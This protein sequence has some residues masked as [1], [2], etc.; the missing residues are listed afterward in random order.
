MMK[1]KVALTLAIATLL[2]TLSQARIAIKKYKGD[3]VIIRQSNGKY[4]LIGT[5]HKPIITNVETISKR[6][7]GYFIVK[8]DEKKGTC[9]N[10]KQLLPLEFSNISLVDYG[11]CLVT[12]D[13]KLGLYTD[14]G[15]QIL[16]PIYQRIKPTDKYSEDEKR[17]FIVKNNKYGICNSDGDFIIEPQYDDITYNSNDYFVMMK[18]NAPE[19]L[20]NTEN[21]IKGVT[22]DNREPIEIQEG[23]ATILY[24]NYKRGDLWGLLN[25]NGRSIIIPQYDNPLEKLTF[26][27]PDSITYLIACKDNRYG[28]IDLNNK[29]IIPF[30]YENIK[31]TYLFNII[32]LSSDS[33]KQLYDMDKKCLALNLFYDKS[34]LTDHYLYLYK[35]VFETVVDF[36]SMQILLPFKYNS[37]VGLN[38]DEH[39][40][41]TKNLQTALI[42]REDKQ[43]IPYG[44]DKITTTESPNLFIVKKQDQYG[45][46]DLQNKLRYGMTSNRIEDLKDY[47]DISDPMTGETIKKLDYQL[48]EVK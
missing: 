37:V 33:G 32:E 2:S 26:I 10:T 40:I 25:R 43:V 38:D 8:K 28:I 3:A 24:Y 16:A 17:Y 7:L 9:D 34:E 12:K 6:N 4:S 42:N 36:N 45:I 30:L 23:L 47:I 39:F 41:V 22:I 48:R 18:D 29:T 14:E 13:N 15:K 5:N 11:F 46:V 20:F 19:Y 1:K 44:Y 35:D 21:I 27:L 31:P